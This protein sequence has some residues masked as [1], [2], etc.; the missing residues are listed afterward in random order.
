S[1]HMAC[2]SDMTLGQ[3][4]YQLANGRLWIEGMPPEAVS[5]IPTV[6]LGEV[7]KRIGP[8]HLDIAGAQAKADGL[9]QGPFEVLAGAPLGAAYP[10]LWNHSAKD[11]RHLTVLP[12][13]HG[14]VR[15][16]AG[17]VPRELQ[18]RAAARWATAS[19]AH[20]NLDVRFNSQSLIVAMTERPCIGGRAWPSVILDNLEHEYALA[21]WCNSTLGLLCHWWSANP[22]QSGRGTTTVTGIPLVSTLDLSSLSSQQHG[23]AKAVF[24][25]LTDARL[26]PFDQ[27][28]EDPSRAELDRRL[29]VDVLGLDACLCQPNG[30]LAILRQKLAAEP[31]IHGGKKTRVVFTADGEESAERD[32]R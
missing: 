32:D 5:T 28:D 4:A 22:T 20:Y 23:M 14:R 10:C 2:V 29:L 8:H 12:D 16:V 9:P 26:L 27:I 18:E 19:R 6:P 17:R 13:A 7:C 1:W 21:L 11:E 15:E 30:P 24:E 31:Q 3:T 25:A